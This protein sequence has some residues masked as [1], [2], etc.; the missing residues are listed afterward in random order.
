MRSLS[1]SFHVKSIVIVKS[2]VDS[3]ES[4]FS[5]FG[6]STLLGIGVFGGRGRRIK[7]VFE[8]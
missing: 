2:T 4:L 7:G 1:L 8:L 5:L 6:V 3:V